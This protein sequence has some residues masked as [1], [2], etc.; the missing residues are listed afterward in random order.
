MPPTFFA[1]PAAFRK[2]LEK[3]HEKESELLVGFYKKDSGKPS[4]TWPESVDQALCFGWIDGV[5]RR[6][7]DVSYSIRFTPRKSISNWSAINIA[8]VA[9]LTKLG[10]MAPAGLRAFQRRRDDKSA[11]YAYENAVRTLAPDDEKRFRANKKAWTYFTAQAPSYQRIAIYWVT[12]AK[13]VE[14]RGR[15]LAALIDDSANGKR[16]DAYTLK[17]KAK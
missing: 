2:W 1:T 7:D 13:R 5:R 16:L 17:P 6:I 14:T 11:I 8:R 12:S 15:R 10:L 9:E 4:I 3:H